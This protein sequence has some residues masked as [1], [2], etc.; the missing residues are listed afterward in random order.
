MGSAS[1]QRMDGGLCTILRA[2]AS[3]DALV[4]VNRVK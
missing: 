4:A 1:V 2:I 3:V